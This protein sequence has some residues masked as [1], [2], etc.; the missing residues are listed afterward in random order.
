MKFRAEIEVPDNATWQDIEDAKIKAQ[1]RRVY[2]REEQMAR[3]NLD[4]KCGS[5]EY[6][7]KDA[8]I[9]GTAYGKCMLKESLKERSMRAM[10]CYKRREDY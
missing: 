9:K 3:T 5:C 7:N 4:N 6:F 2:T 8:G 10:S 1:W